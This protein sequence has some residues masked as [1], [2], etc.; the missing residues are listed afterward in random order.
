MR[1]E[2]TRQIVKH[3]P[4]VRVPR[5]EHACRRSVRDANPASGASGYLLKDSADVDLIQAVRRVSQGNRSSALAI[6]RLML[7]RLRQAT[8]RRTGRS[9]IATRRCR[10]REREVFSADRRGENEQGHRR[11]A[12]HQP[13][14]RS[15]RIRA[16]ILEKLDVH[17]A[18]EIVLYAVRRGVIR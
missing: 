8:L 3:V 7:E 6:A 14:A 11:A 9:S 5:T 10:N 4:G 12:L 1:V 2:A 17:S 13:R 16:R 18:A 15:R